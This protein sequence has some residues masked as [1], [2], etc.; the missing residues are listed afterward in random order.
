MNLKSKKN[1]SISLAIVLILQGLMPVQ[2]FPQSIS[3][4][5]VGA[6]ISFA[7]TF[8]LNPSLGS[9]EEWHWQAQDKPMVVLIRDAHAIR[10]AQI[11]TE[12]IISELQKK[13]N[14]DL[15]LLEGAEGP[16]DARLLKTFPDQDM[17]KQ[18]LSGYIAS[19]DIS[20]AVQA[21]V[22]SPSTVQAFGIED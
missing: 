16:L 19:G 7:D 21:I 10:E 20:G 4:L 2:V 14:L 6:M 3:T 12:E 18:V 9:I 15:I 1:L 8:Q 22:N 17:L 13:W 5:A 11:H